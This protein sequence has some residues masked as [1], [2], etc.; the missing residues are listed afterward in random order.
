MTTFH[1]EIMP[2]GQ[3]R[4][5]KLLGGTAARFNFYL[6]GGTAL[7]I[8]LGHRESV[9][10]DWFTSDGIG[11]PLILADA[12]RADGLPFD[13]SGVAPGT[14]HGSAED[15]KLSFL[16]YRYPLLRPVLPWPEY[17]CSLASMEDLACMKL[18]AIGSRGAKKDFID[19]YAL[20]KTKF[21]LAQMLA[22]YQEKFE[23]T[24]LLH[25]LSSLTYFDDAEAEDTPKLLWN[26]DWR[27]IK[28][29]VGEWV[30]EYVHTRAPQP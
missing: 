9:D 14:L 21:S 11:D 8:Y 23:T 7:A 16:E 3:Q 25:V 10:L 30:T 6:A 29:T 12:L 24:D 4:V 2:A 18:S 26:L 15:V 5:L 17:G 19:L 1:P 28:R 22:F 13:V 20:G 27:E